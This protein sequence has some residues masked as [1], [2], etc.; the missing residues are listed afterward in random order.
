MG[1]ENELDPDGIEVTEELHKYFDGLEKELGITIGPRKRAWYVAKKAQQ[2]DDMKREFPGTPEEAFE[3]AV[4]G[5]Y[6]ADIVAGMTHRGQ[7]GVV[8]IDRAYQVNSGWDFGISDT[9]TIWLHQ[10]IAMQD[11]LVGFI[12]GTD[13]DVLYYWREMKERY[14]DVIWGT[15]YL[16]HD[17]ESRRIGTSQDAAAPPKTLEKILN[18][19]GMVGTQIVPRLHSKAIGIQEVKLWLPKAFIDKLN[20]GTSHINPITHKPD[21]STNGIKCLQNFRREWDEKGGC[22]KNTPLHNWAQHGYDGLETLV[23]GLNAYTTGKAVE[24]AKR[25]ARKKADWRNRMKQLRRTGQ[26]G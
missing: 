24:P 25:T 7:I 10:R 23:R 3:A 20:C 11:R 4:E 19:A 21:D 15:H 14:P 18:E 26:A 16:P 1:D 5:A 6:L 9:M 13:Q 12:A 8:P 22:W 17:G 2:K